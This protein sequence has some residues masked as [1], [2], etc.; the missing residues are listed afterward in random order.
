MAGDRL[1]QSGAL[2]GHEVA[3]RFKVTRLLGEG[4]MG[5]VYVAE[6]TVLQQLF[7]LKV[8]KAHI[9]QDKNLSAR[10]RREAQIASRLEHPNIVFISD[11]GSMPN[12][13]LYLVM[14]YIEGLS[15]RA[16]MDEAQDRRMPQVRALKILKQ[17]A[18]AMAHAHQCDVVHRDIKPDNVLLGRRAD[19][20]DLV[21]ILDFGL[22]KMVGSTDNLTRRGDLFGSPLYMSPEQCRGEP[23]D[24]RADIYALGIVAYE[25]FTGQTPFNFKSIPRMIMAHLGDPVPPPTSILPDGADGLAPELEQLILRC[26][27]KDRDARPS[28]AL[29]LV[30][31][32]DEFLSRHQETIDA[33]ATRRAPPPPPARGGVRAPRPSEEL[34]PAPS[35]LLVGADAAA[36]QQW[37]WNQACKAA[38]ELADWLVKRGKASNELAAAIDDLERLAESEL[39]LQTDVALTVSQIDEVEVELREPIAQLRHAVVDLRVERDTL[40]DQSGVNP[41]QVQD[42]DFQVQ[43]LER[44]LAEVYAGRERRT[45]AIKGELAVLEQRLTSVQQDL[46]D[47]ERRLIGLVRWE[48]PQPCPPATARKYVALEAMVEHLFGA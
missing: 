39:L 45:A 2:V 14:E 21:K 43:A 19:G 32:V 18:G 37:Y 6:H 44:R 36:L 16:A 26:L 15:L 30:Q 27:E 46:T 10:F 31:V 34:P 7:A 13:M 40:M 8:L 25:L 24:H 20:G 3:G 33:A 12:G 1:L 41:Q 42:L 5:E 22:A 47:Y 4:A 9:A 11:F 29:D 48:K 23:A 17:L 38:R 28:S 35:M